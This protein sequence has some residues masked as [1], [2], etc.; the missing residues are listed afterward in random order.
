MVEQRPYKTWV[1]GS[2]PS[3]RTEDMDDLIIGPGNLAGKGLYAGRDFKKGEVV[4]RYKLEQISEEEYEELPENEKMFTHT[5]WGQIYLYLEPGR[6]VNHAKD[7][8][9]V[10]DIRNQ[11]DL[12]LRDIKKG[13]MITCDAAKDDVE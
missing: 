13:E 4:L 5:H 9:T 6:Y 12:A 8:N 3:G 10:Q 1:L 2:I 7:P 11:C